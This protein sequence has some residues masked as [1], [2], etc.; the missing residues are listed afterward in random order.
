MQFLAPDVVVLDPWAAV[1][2]DYRDQAPRRGDF[3]LPLPYQ[4][5]KTDADNSGCAEPGACDAP[6]SGA[7]AGGMVA[8]AAAAQGGAGLPTPQQ[9]TG[10]GSSS[11]HKKRKQGTSYQPN[12]RELE[13]AARHVAFAPQLAAAVAAVQEWLRASGASTI[14][15]ALQTVASGS[16]SEQNSTRSAAEHQRVQGAPL[17]PAAAGAANPVGA[18]AAAAEAAAAA[19]AEAAPNGVNPEAPAALEPDYRAMFE[20]RYTLRP[21]LQLA[22]DT[23]T[24]AGAAAAGEAAVAAPCEQDVQQPPAV[25]LFNRLIDSECGLDQGGSSSSSGGEE[26]GGGGHAGSRSR[27]RSGGRERLAWAGGHPV[28]LPPSSR[29]LMSDARQLAPLVADAQGE[30]K[31]PRCE[32]SRLQG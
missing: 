22:A 30:S 24:A 10:G 8:A 3:S 9:P 28:L 12:K 31:L 11:K 6:G 15:Q 26:V 18:A 13:A 27:Q 4:T 16:A 1:A 19:G 20:L 29:F 14:Q 5:I 17:E 32:V 21:K 25:N 23:A 7:D 2:A